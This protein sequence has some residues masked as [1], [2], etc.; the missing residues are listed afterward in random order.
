[1]RILLIVGLLFLPNC[2]QVTRPVTFAKVAWSRCWPWRRAESIQCNRP[3]IARRWKFACSERTRME[4]EPEIHK[5]M[6]STFDRRASW[7]VGEKSGRMNGSVLR[8]QWSAVK[9]DW[10]I[11][12]RTRSALASLLP[13]GTSRHRHRRRQDERHHPALI[14]FVVGVVL[15][16]RRELQRR[17]F[18]LCWATVDRTVLLFSSFLVYFVLEDCFIVFIVSFAH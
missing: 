17:L 8:I 3:S 1:M 11:V 7:S 12:T 13:V 15:L 4:V 5:V 18:P 16:F 2:S 10:R 6:H 9:F 14:L